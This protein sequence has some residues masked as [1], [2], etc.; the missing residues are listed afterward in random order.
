MGKVGA[1]WA[2]QFN[3]S[4]AF[5]KRA[6]C[7]PNGVEI[8]IFL[9]KSINHTAT[10]A[11]PPDHRLYEMIE[12]QHFAQRATQSTHFSNKKNFNFQAPS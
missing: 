6:K 1:E 7:D 10:N 2:K 12:L 5:K 9:E 8:V 11:P 3:F 4:T